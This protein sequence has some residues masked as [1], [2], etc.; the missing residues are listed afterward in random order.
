MNEE[1]FKETVVYTMGKGV[2]QLG[3][4]YAGDIRT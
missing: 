2:G 3:M 4:N 1:G